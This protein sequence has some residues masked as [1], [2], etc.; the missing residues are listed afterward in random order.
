MANR[1]VILM[2]QNIKHLM[3][4]G[5]ANFVIQYLKLAIRWNFIYGI[6]I[7]QNMVHVA[8]D[9]KF[10]IKVLLKKIQKFL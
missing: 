1:N 9:R 8:K 5:N 3:E 7:I 6:N 10:G 2:Q 4:H